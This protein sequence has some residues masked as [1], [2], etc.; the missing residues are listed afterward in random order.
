ME[1]KSLTLFLFSWCFPVST[2]NMLFKETVL[3]LT[4]RSGGCCHPSPCLVCRRFP[5]ASVGVLPC[6]RRERRNQGGRTQFAPPPCPVEPARAVT[7]HRPEHRSTEHCRAA[8][9]WS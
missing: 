3:P 2:E 9:H 8:E 4:T 5:C 6:C 7:E 1:P